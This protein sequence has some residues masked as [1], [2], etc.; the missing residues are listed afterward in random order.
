VQNATLA[1]IHP[2][3]P[4]SKYVAGQCRIRGSHLVDPRER[5]IF[6]CACLS[7]SKDNGYNWCAPI[8]KFFPRPGRET[9]S[10]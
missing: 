10:Q 7:E 8:R 5:P 9:P 6:S 3:A 1:K 2:F 4:V